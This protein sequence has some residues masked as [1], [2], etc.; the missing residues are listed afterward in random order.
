MA[1][2]VDEEVPDALW[3]LEDRHVQVQVQPVDALDLQGD[4]L[5]QN[6]RNTTCYCHGGLLVSQVLQ[7]PLPREA[8]I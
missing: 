7:G 6:F 2:V 5:A 1:S 3:G 4:V 8:A